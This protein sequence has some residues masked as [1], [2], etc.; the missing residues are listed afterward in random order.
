MISPI[1]F[2]G[3][4]KAGIGE[5]TT[6]VDCEKYFTLLNACDDHNIPNKQKTTLEKS[7]LDGKNVFT[8][9]SII[10]CPERLDARLEHFCAVN[11]IKITKIDKPEGIDI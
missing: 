7:S 10:H 4:Y 11:N 3:Y 5:R 1:S 8:E 6:R 2:S 9:E